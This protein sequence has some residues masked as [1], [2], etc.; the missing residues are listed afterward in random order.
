MT[1]SFD[2]NLETAMLEFKC[3]F[4]AMKTRLSKYSQTSNASL[5]ISNTFM[6][7]VKRALKTQDSFEVTFPGDSY[8]T[9]FFYV[10]GEMMT[11]DYRF[12]EGRRVI[13]PNYSAEHFEALSLKGLLI[14]LLSK[15]EGTREMD[16]LRIA[17]M[18]HT[19]AAGIGNA[20]IHSHDYDLR[21]I[22]LWISIRLL[23]NYGAI[24]AIG[25]GSDSYSFALEFKSD[26]P[27]DVITKLKEHFRDSLVATA[28]TEKASTEEE[29]PVEPMD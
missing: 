12:P 27:P 14:G 24:M 18:L 22:M 17:V 3:E 11:S 29:D 26:T 10:G 25:E 13:T 7:D 19:I 23:R 5:Q 21:M 2:A 9:K 4:E 15:Q 16:A 28:S 1:D 8:V 6:E 20:G